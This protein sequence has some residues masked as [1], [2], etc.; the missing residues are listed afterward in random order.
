M[1]MELDVTMEEG[2]ME[3]KKQRESDFH[4]VRGY[5]CCLGFQRPLASGNSAYVLGG[6]IEA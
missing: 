3:K 4:E 1:R 6:T 2:K 5:T